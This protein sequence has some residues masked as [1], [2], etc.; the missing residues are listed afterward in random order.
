MQA[1]KR[2]TFAT[3]LRKSGL[4]VSNFFLHS[5]FFDSCRSPY[6]ESPVSTPN[7]TPRGVPE[8]GIGNGTNASYGN[9]ISPRSANGPSIGNGMGSRQVYENGGG[10]SHNVDSSPDDLINFSASAQVRST[11]AP[12][13][14]VPL[15]YAPHDLYSPTRSD[16]LSLGHRITNKISQKIHGTSATNNYSHNLSS[17]A[18]S[19]GSSLHTLSYAT[20][21]SYT[22]STVNPSFSNLSYAT[23]NSSYMPVTSYSIPNSYS[24]PNPSPMYYRPPG[25]T[26]TN[27]AYTP[28]PTASTST[29]TN[30]SRPD[31]FSSLLTNPFPSSTTRSTSSSQRPPDPPTYSTTTR[32]TT[33]LSHQRGTSPVHQLS[34]PATTSYTS[35]SSRGISPS[36]QRPTEHTSPAARGVSPSHQRPLDYYSRG[37]S[38]SRTSAYPPAPT[39][40]STSS[41][42]STTTS[43]QRPSYDLHLYSA[44][45][46]RPAPEPPIHSTQSTTPS[47]ATRGVSPARRPIDP[48]LP[49]SY[50]SNGKLTRNPSPIRSQIPSAS[51]STAT[52]PVR[53]QIPPTTS[54]T[55][56]MSKFVRPPARAQ[57]DA[58]SSLYS[59]ID[60]SGYGA[61]KYYPRD[62]LDTEVETF[63]QN[64][65]LTEHQVFIYY[66]LFI[67]H[68]PFVC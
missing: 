59:H 22:T 38:A 17:L 34:S 18:P 52:S 15:T 16:D 4:Y 36:R 39:L 56:L 47:Y 27:S 55:G 21:P 33:S 5:N 44:S 24:T 26:P 58:P 60:K 3:L 12:P 8:N 42:R 54:T 62:S 53:T 51:S 30:G 43:P 31:P 7:T 57:S 10:A 45:P 64:M 67:L 35:P 32:E 66:Y 61:N 63:L 2:S 37:L 49:A 20:P 19:R 23:P 48:S 28:P 13:T 50:L 11:Q 1:W 46:S 9:S 29:T 40:N 68:Y 25:S 65:R 6:N 14:Y 41:S